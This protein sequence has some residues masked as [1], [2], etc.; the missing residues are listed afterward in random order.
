MKTEIVFQP[1][2]DVSAS[3]LSAK[4]SA[5]QAVIFHSLH[6]VSALWLLDGHFFRVPLRKCFP[7]IGTWFS[8]RCWTRKLG[9]SPGR[10]CQE[11]E[12]QQ[13]ARDH[14]P[15]LLPTHAM[16]DLEMVIWTAVTIGPEHTFFVNLASENWSIEQQNQRIFL[17]TLMAISSRIKV[18][19]RP[20]FHLQCSFCCL[21]P[22]NT[23]SPW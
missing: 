23:S 19:T 15:P 9:N 6:S 8:F 18:Y 21:H 3:F 22:S 12:R 4:L 16:S 17:I 14:C 2:V 13:Q 7:I 11:R 10:Q 20:Y 1:K 5:K